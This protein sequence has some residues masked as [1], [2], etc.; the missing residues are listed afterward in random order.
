MTKEDLENLKTYIK[1]KKYITDEIY[2]KYIANEINNRNLESYVETIEFDDDTECQFN[3][4]EKIIKIN[5]NEILYENNLKGIPSLEQIISN[6]ERKTGKIKDINNVNLYNYFII[7][8]ELEHVEQIKLLNNLEPNDNIDDL[9]LIWRYLLLLKD[10]ILENNTLMYFKDMPY[11]TYHD[12]YIS[13]YDANINSYINTLNFFNDLDIDEI[14][15]NIIIFNRIIAQNIL[16]LYRDI[17]N[18][19]IFSTPSQNFIKL[20]NHIKKLL[21]K[22]N[23]DVDDSFFNIF[24]DTKKPSSQIDRL[25]LGFSINKNTYKYL[26][27]VSKEKHKTLNLFNDIM[28]I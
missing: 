4:Q 6:S 28:N 3:G 26:T 5:P 11:K 21:K 14:N 9:Y 8:H 13:E 25:K 7:N 17:E 24:A 2:I 20:Y 22:R 15:K 23:I 12:Y 19:R 27:L 18:R 16:F 10:V 1:K